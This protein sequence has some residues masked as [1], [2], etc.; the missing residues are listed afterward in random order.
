M[1]HI[2]GL[3]LGQA[4]DRTALVLLAQRDGAVKHLDVVG[5]KR[6]PIGVPYP[7][8]VADVVQTLSAPSLDD[9]LL[10]IDG[11]GVGR[12][13]V[14]LFRQQSRVSFRAI[15]ITAGRDVLANGGYINVPKSDLVAAVQVLLQEQRLHFD[16]SH[17]LTSLLVSELQDFQIKI[18]DAANATYNARTGKHDDLVLALAIG[19]WM[20]ERR[21]PGVR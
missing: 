2:A 13:V 15:T 18:T 9:V 10:V 11:T 17:P 14:D 16:S 1:R 12:G 4:N 6:Y 21:R 5:I 7:G 19:A 20:A 3:D 8:I